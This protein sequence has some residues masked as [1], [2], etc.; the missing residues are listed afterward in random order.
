MLTIRRCG[1]SLAAVLGLTLAA[2]AAAA[3][4]PQPRAMEA[5]LAR[6]ELQRVEDAGRISH[7]RFP[8]YFPV[9]RHHGTWRAADNSVLLAIHG[10][11][12]SARRNQSVSLELLFGDSASFE[13]GLAHTGRVMEAIGLT[14][15]V[16]A[17]AAE[18]IRTAHAARRA[19]R[20]AGGA[21]YLTMTREAREVAGIQI[22]MRFEDL[23]HVFVH[24][25]NA[26]APETRWPTRDDVERLHPD[27]HRRIRPEAYDYTLFQEPI[28]TRL[29]CRRAGRDAFRCSYLLDN[30]AIPGR[31]VDRYTGL[32]RR[33]ADGEWT[34]A[35][36][37]P[38][39]P[40]G[41]E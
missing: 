4:V 30:D 24:F 35:L 8:L 1:F 10:H 25:T 13:T 37:Q 14:G 32:F 17:A 29:Q 11:G 22:R 9:D 21:W 38:P 16:R 36:D 31:P 7:D 23:S 2:G 33:R 40:P 39:H 18:L 20:R 41:T 12:R 34:V 28:V 27:T 6:L 19:E 26:D 3:Q 15:E 5:A